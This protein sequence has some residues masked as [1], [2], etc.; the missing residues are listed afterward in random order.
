MIQALPP[1]ILAAFKVQAAVEHPR[2]ACALVVELPNK[3]YAFRSCRN[4]A[5]DPLGTFT[6][7]PVDWDRVEDEG[8]V[9]AVLHSHPSTPAKASAHDRVICAEC[10]IPWFILGRGGELFRIDPSEV[11]SLDKLKTGIFKRPLME[12]FR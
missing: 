6:L 12:R 5:E 10:G 8:P 7:D 9:V 3:S 11:S 1:D 4:I 2:E